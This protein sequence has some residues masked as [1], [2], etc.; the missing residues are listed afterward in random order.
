FSGDLNYGNYNFVQA[1][2]SLGGAIVE[3][4]LLIRLSGVHR[5]RDGFIRNTTTGEKL[6]D[7]NSDGARAVVVA[8]VSP[9]V[10]LR[11]SADYFGEEGTTAV[12]TGPV[13]LA[14]LPAFA[15]IPPQ[16]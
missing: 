4:K 12:E 6:N 13:T 3:D 8:K 5:Q 7:L 16:D 11:L 15:G 1:R 14:A 10:T 2:G 9:A